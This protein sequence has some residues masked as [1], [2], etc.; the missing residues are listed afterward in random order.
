[1][2]VIR[3]R[4]FF[5]G[6][7]EPLSLGIDEDGRIAAIKKVLRGDEEIDHGDAL[8]LPGC[9]DLHVHM[10]DPGL[11]HKEDFPSGTRS[12]A[13]GGVTTLADMPNTKP[14]VTTRATLEAKASR[15]QGRAAVD[16]VLY[17]APQSAQAVSSLADAAAFKLYMAESTGSL[18]VDVP[19]METIFRAAEPQ[20]KLVVIHAE[21]PTMFT[22]TKGGGLGGYSAVRPKEAEVS[23]LATLARIRGDAKV[24]VAHV[25]C[26][27]ALDAMPGNGTCEVTPHHLFLDA[28]RPL[29]AFGKVNPPLRSPQ[30][31]A[32]L[33]DAFRSGRIDAVASDHAPHTL[34][35]KG[36]PFDESPAGLPGVATCFPLL[37]RRSGSGDLELPRLVSGTATRPA[38]IIGIPKGTIDIGRDADLITVDP[39]RIE[40]VTT[41][42]VRYKCGWTPFEGMEA[43]FPRAVYLRGELIVEDGEP[44]AEMQGRLLRPAP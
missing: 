43:C 5:R 20:K 28:S 23:A 4:V 6:Q 11:T 7:L 3:G 18:E 37:M 34:E 24:H 14:A 1:M 41:K 26:V 22:K 32:A 36:E 35:E 19:H 33:W 29:G 27:E 8:I 15:L 21:D 9:V 31:R 39:R 38:E 12:A 42:R 25:T 30:D 17:A 13:I 16:F 40:K 10:R 2:R 44:V